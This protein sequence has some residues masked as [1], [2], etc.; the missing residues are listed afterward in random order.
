[1][2]L[3]F[4]LRDAVELGFI[5]ALLGFG[6]FISFRILH[7][8]DLS[9][10][11]TFAFGG[12]MMAA[13]L[14]EQVS[15]VLALLASFLAGALAG[16]IT[17]FLH[18]KAKIPGLL[19]GIITMTGLYSI[20]LRVLSGRATVSL[21]GVDTLFSWIHSFLPDRFLGTALMV[22]GLLILVAF[23]LYWFF[24]TELGCAI[25]ATGS[26]PAMARAQGV[27]T[28]RMILIGLALSNGLAALGGALLAQQQGFADI[29]MGRGV[30]VIGI[31]A[32]IIG[33]S[34]FGRRSFKN[35][36]ISVVLGTITY[37]LLIGLAIS[38]G[39]YPNDLKLLSAVLVATILALPVLRKKIQGGMRHAGTH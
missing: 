5:W 4:V 14:V 15:P 26:N 10:D 37:Y 19:S 8:S 21:L 1:M 2:G 38:A 12:A 3:E 16:L 25:R 17:G 32:I 39:F 36:L 6:V 11:G 29:N 22:G 30:I 33:E 9:V 34:L 20:N 24:G 27:A 28:D 23:A 7:F 31:A 13:L 18:T 35:S